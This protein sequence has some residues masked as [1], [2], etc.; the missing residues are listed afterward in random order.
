MARI[1]LPMFCPQVTWLLN[2]HLFTPFRPPVQAKC[3]LYHNALEAVGAEC[4]DCILGLVHYYSPRVHFQSIYCGTWGPGHRG[5]WAPGPGS[6][7]H[8]MPG[9]LV[10]GAPGWPRASGS[11]PRAPGPGLLGRD[12]GAP[13]LGPGAW[14]RINALNG[15]WKGGGCIPPF[16]GCRILPSLSHRLPL[17]CTPHGNARFAYHMPLSGL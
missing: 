13:A 8:P 17:R 11:G 12:P 5:P 3:L 15:A 7:G 10:P 9:P 1:G 6:Q 14:A 16:K 2:K 4:S